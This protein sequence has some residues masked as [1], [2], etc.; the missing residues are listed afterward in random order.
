MRKV[1]PEASMLLFAEKEWAGRF[2]YSGEICHC[3]K[4]ASPDSLRAAKYAE[5]NA[6]EKGYQR[7]KSQ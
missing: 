6:V 7:G 3:R 4:R 1:R 5:M 2:A